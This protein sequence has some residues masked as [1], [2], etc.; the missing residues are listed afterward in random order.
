MADVQ[1]P[2]EAVEAAARVVLKGF[3]DSTPMEQHWAREGAVAMLNA[4]APF[5]AAAVL[6][7]TAQRFMNDLNEMF[8]DDEVI[9]GPVAETYLDEVKKLR[10]RAAELR[11]AE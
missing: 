4:S 3:D 8:E 11:G 1:I 5:I 9:A 2:R 10:A 7:H 6:E